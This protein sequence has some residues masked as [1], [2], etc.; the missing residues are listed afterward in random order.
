MNREEIKSKIR[1]KQNKIYMLANEIKE[2][3]KESY[4]LSDEHQQFVEKYE[5]VL[6][7]GRSKKY[8]KQLVGRIHWVEEYG[9][10]DGGTLMIDRS[11]VVRLDGK[12]I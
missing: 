5:D 11:K 6:V 3:T 4:L 7:F 9:D 12:W 1:Q 8:K 10:G 2:L